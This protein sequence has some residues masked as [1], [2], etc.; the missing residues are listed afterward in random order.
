MALEFLVI[1]ITIVI[2]FIAN[3]IFDKTKISYVIFLILF[4]ILLGPVLGLLDV[5][6][7]SLIVSILPFIASVALIFLLFEGGI[8]FDIF[9]LAGSIP[10]STLY[11][12]LTFIVGT[13]AISIF[14][15]A[16]LGW[17]ILHGAL[18]GAIIGGP[19]GAVVISMIQNAKIRKDIKSL[20]TV[21][22]TLTDALVIITAVILMQVI[23]SD[24]DLM[25]K[26]IFGLFL[27][28]FSNA[29]AI[30]LLGG[31]IWI[32]FMNKFELH[33]YSYML[34]IA[35]LLGLFAVAEE[36]GASGGIAVFCFGLVLGNARKLAKFVNVEW[37][38]PLSRTNRLFQEEVIFFVRTFFFVYV[39]LLMSLNYFTM[40]VMV[41]SIGLV[42]LIMIIRAGT[43]KLILGEMR[44]RDIKIVTTVMPRGLAAAVVAT[45]PAISGIVLINFQ[46][47]VF[48]VILL[49]NIIATAGVFLFEKE[50]IEIKN[51][52]KQLKKNHNREEKK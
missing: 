15:T 14:C 51:N 8:E 46:E 37:I 47:Y 49:T 28:S 36:A 35:L 23:T 39:G 43:A 18:L 20:L 30:G 41:V 26:A 21:E 31:F 16:F 38:N 1:G 11:T 42:V 50:D 9:R 32:F 25:P 6:A 10:K 29:I 27:A 22:S 7:E 44:R 19:S 40:D 33:M 45:L 3:Q 2:G 48:T 12:F 17:D 4:G 34:M 24:I 52:G 13:L 5:S